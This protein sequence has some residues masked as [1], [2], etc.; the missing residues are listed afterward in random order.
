MAVNAGSDGKESEHSASVLAIKGL[1]SQR[2]VSVSTLKVPAMGTWASELE[3][4]AMVARSDH[5]SF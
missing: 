3:Y 2:P 4:G 1:R 5:V